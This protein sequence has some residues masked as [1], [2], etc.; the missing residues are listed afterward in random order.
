MNNH[1]DVEKYF[2]TQGSYRG[3]TYQFG[4]NFSDV[5]VSL[6]QQYYDNNNLRFLL[7]D[8][9]ISLLWLTRALFKELDNRFIHQA[10]QK[11]QNMSLLFDNKT[12][13]KYH[14]SE[15][16]NALLNNYINFEAPP[17]IT[18]RG[19]SEV[20]KCKKFAHDNRHLL[21]EDEEKFILRLSAQF[22]LKNPP[23]KLQKNNSGR[24][25]FSSL[26][27]EEIKIVVD[28]KVEKAKALMAEH[29]DVCNKRYK[30]ARNMQN[31]S[32]A[33]KLWLQELKPALMEALFQ[34]GLRKFGP[35]NFSFEKSFLEKFGFEPCMMCC[36]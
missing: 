22:A 33:L 9:D 14:K 8:R 27:L 31:D 11:T 4:I 24:Y 36:K 17:E 23:V 10:R 15:H 1:T 32:E 18:A 6:C 34:Y 7:T 19:E 20:L 5:T 29:Q 2:I 30:P 35:K 26:S 21:Q 3:L 12:T 25:Q 13:P 16:C 28:E